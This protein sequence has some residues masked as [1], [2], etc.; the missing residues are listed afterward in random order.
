MKDQQSSQAAFECVQSELGDQI[1]RLD[2]DETAAELNTRLKHH[3]QV[4]DS[5]RLTQA[6][7][8]KLATA[9]DGGHLTI[10]PEPTIGSSW[11]Q[12]I[13][14]VGG[15]AL[16]ASLALVLLMPPGVMPFGSFRGD[17]STMIV[18]PVEGEVLTDATPQ[19]TWPSVADASAYRVS[20]TGIDSSY[21]W[22]AR[23]ETTTAQIPETHALPDQ[24]WFRILV[25][26]LPTDLAPLGE[27]SVVFRRGGVGD[28]MVW[29][30]QHAPRPIQWLVWLSGAI[31]VIG[32]VLKQ[33]QPGG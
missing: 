6:L 8:S 28:V 29:R 1:W 13:M 32:F 9:A 21:Q 17:A 24:G 4:C 20:L 7:D 14:A 18:T 31:F 2:L 30:A 23:I 27:N 22:S 10:A 12:G 25:E 26:P 16:A 15:M 11:S 5:C 19:V 3:L 33:R